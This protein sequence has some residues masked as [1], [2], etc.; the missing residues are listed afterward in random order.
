MVDRVTNPP[1]RPHVIPWTCEYVTLNG[2][3]DFAV[4]F[5]FKPFKEIDFQ[6][7][8]DGLSPISGSL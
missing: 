1:K 5:K 8:L 6:D 7:Y 3:K 2:K 4:V